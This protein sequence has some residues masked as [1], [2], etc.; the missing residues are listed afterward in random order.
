[1]AKKFDILVIGAGAAG[2]PASIFASRAGASVL[3]VEAADRIGGTF[4]LSS[5]QMS[6]ARYAH[7]GRQG[8]PRHPTIPL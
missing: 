3:V 5:G 2:L 7:P 1:M 4:H 6:A 8:H